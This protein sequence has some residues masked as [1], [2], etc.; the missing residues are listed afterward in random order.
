M[1]TLG[2]EQNLSSKGSL[3]GSLIFND[4]PFRESTLLNNS[5]VVFKSQHFQIGQKRVLQSFREKITETNSLLSQ[6][7]SKLINKIKI[8]QVTANTIL[9]VSQHGSVNQLGSLLL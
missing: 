5:K 4:I 7:Q 9:G 2:R 6:Y 1:S 8:A 3:L